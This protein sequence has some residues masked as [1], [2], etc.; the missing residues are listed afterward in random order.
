[1]KTIHCI[2]IETFLL[3]VRLY[4]DVQRQRKCIVCAAT[5]YRFTMGL[6]N[7]RVIEYRSVNIFYYIQ[8]TYILYEQKPYFHLRVPFSLF[9]LLPVSFVFI[10]QFHITMR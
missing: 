9:P 10:I 2:R 1:M 3:S 4:I 5:I 8:I 7:L 6:P